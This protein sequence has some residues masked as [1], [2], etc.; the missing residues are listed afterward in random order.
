MI[1]VRIKKDNEIVFESNSYKI[2]GNAD[3]LEFDF[4][5]LSNVDLSNVDLINANLANANLSGANLGNAD[6]SGANL[7]FADLSY[8][9]LS[10]ANLSYADLSYA[11][12]SYAKLRHTNLYEATLC[13]ADLYN[14]ILDNA[15]LSNAILDKKEKIRQGIVLDKSMI[16][17][18]KA[19]TD[20]KSV[21]V[22]LE[23]PKNAIVFSINNNKCRTNI[24]KVIDI[25]GDFNK[26][27]S[28]YDNKFVYEKGK[29]IRIKDF[30]L[31]YNVECGTGI[32]FFR[33]KQEA[34][35]YNY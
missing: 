27:Y 16:V 31:Q 15:N 19:V 21:I 18:K 7:S 34:L 6:L 29:T 4:Y 13:N 30:N 3:F 2:Y 12:L 11:D 9:D 23:I 22:T 32:H 25:E 28:F 5:K 10:G 24:C 14:T 26:A 8:A 17:Y 1:K 35:D 33:T 20:D